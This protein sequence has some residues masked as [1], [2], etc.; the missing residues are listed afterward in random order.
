MATT[1]AATMPTNAAVL[2]AE[3]C[4]MGGTTG[5]IRIET[6]EA[7]ASTMIVTLSERDLLLGGWLARE[8]TVRALTDFARAFGLEP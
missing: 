7:G 8:G 5:E 2:A 6:T 3:G 4:A 1:T